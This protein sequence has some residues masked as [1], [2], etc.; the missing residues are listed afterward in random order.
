MPP[1]PFI[2]ECKLQLVC[3]IRERYRGAD[4]REKSKIL[5]EFVAVAE[6]HRKHAIRLLAGPAEGSGGAKQASGKRI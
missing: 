2:R 4:R 6:C 5:D 1:N 3:A